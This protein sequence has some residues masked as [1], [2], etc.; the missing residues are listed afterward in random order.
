[1]IADLKATR[2]PVGIGL[3]HQNWEPAHEVLAY[4]SDGLGRVYVYDPNVPYRKGS[5][6]LE[7]ETTALKFDGENFTYTPYEDTYQYYGEDSE[8]AKN[9]FFP[10][11]VPNALDGDYK[12][13][14][15]FENIYEDAQQEFSDDIRPDITVNNYE[16]GDT[17]H[18]Q[19]ITLT[20]RIDSSGTLI[21]DFTVINTAL[22]GLKSFTTAVEQSG[23]FSI[24][25]RLTEGNNRLL[26]VAK[27]QNVTGL[28]NF[29]LTYEE[30]TTSSGGCGDLAL[31][32]EGLNDSDPDNAKGN[33]LKV[34]TDNEGHW[35]T[36]TPSI[37]V[38][39][40]LGYSL[41]Y[42][43]I[44]SGDTYASV[45]IEN[46]GWGPIGGEFAQFRQDGIDD[47]GV[48][49]VEPG[50]E[51][52]DDTNVGVGGQFDR[53][54]EK[55]NELEFGGRTEWRRPTEPELSNFVQKYEGAIQGLWTARGWPTDHT[56]WS[57]TVYGS[58]YYYSVSLYGG[59][60][61]V[62]SSPVDR[63]ASCVLEHP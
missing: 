50:N 36:S 19:W 43:Y 42:S 8:A 7:G 1:M 41:D 14:E 53:W 21:T 34:A 35:F 61:G 25:V 56:Y 32:G 20:G 3:H 47:N 11:V 51:N 2:K 33:C 24:P 12:L 57:S 27:G 37:A 23:E 48:Q 4:R 39:N 29:Y 16:S 17:V 38:M 15:S 63:Y 31:C 54:C 30:G 5:P 9:T 10:Q 44:N 28:S 6:A 55:L 45:Y 59:G 58:I 18:H 60:L 62:L 49:V 46:G 52:A 22:S 13:K 26:F 40:A